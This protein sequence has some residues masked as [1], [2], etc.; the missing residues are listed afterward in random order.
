MSFAYRLCIL[1]VSLMLQISI[2]KKRKKLEIKGLLY[3]ALKQF[4]L[5][6]S[7]EFYYSS[8]KKLVEET[9]K[10]FPDTSIYRT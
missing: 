9:S 3:R 5:I 1:A 2:W 4:K 6:L 10:Y 8:E 7:L